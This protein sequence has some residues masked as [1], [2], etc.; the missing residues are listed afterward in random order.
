M[1]WKGRLFSV[2]PRIRLTRSFDQSHHSYLGYV[3]GV[4]GTVGDEAEPRDLLVGIGKAAQ[5]KHEFQ[6]GDEVSGLGVPVDDPR[7][8]TVEL[9]KMARKW[10][11]NILTM[12]ENEVFEIVELKDYDWE[13]VKKEAWK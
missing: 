13:K 8:E 4:H 5:A 10:A 12:P 7:K 9:Y 11:F 3:L 2:Q 1:A 6:V